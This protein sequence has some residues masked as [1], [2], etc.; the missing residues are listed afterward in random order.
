MPPQ[1]FLEGTSLIFMFLELNKWLCWFFGI[2]TL[3]VAGTSQSIH[4]ICN[5]KPLQTHPPEHTTS[6]DSAPIYKYIRLLPQMLNKPLPKNHWTLPRMCISR[7]VFWISQPPVTWDPM[8]FLGL[9]QLKK[10]IFNSDLGSLIGGWTNP[11]GKY[12]STWAT[13]KTLTTFHYTGCLIGI[14]DPHNGLL[15][16]L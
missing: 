10:H 4:S 6:Q 14:L 15:Y 8:I 9:I 12:E 7:G 16:S 1:F 3:L 13:K 2:C 5:S 11:L